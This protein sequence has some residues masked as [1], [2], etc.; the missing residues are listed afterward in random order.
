MGSQEK[1]HR[2]TID[3]ECLLWGEL[4]PTTAKL[5]QRRFTTGFDFHKRSLPLI[6]Y[7]S[8]N[9]RS[10][11]CRVCSNTATL[12]DILFFRRSYPRQRAATFQCVYEIR[13]TDRSDAEEAG[14]SYRFMGR[15][16]YHSITE[17]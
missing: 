7:S 12:R 6:C 13:Q 3:T 16:Y 17:R 2:Y 11:L 8:T 5:Q 9:S 14:L 1:Q 10:Q 4:A 15:H